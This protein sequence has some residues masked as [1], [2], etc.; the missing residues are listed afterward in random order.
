MAGGTWL[1]G[2]LDLLQSCADVIG[3]LRMPSPGNSYTV[4]LSPLKDVRRIHVAS[5]K[6]GV[7][8]SLEELQEGINQ[9]SRCVGHGLST[10]NGNSIPLLWC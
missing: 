6:R 7:N 4:Q 10:S 8:G 1:L 2:Y 3:D 5:L 9:D